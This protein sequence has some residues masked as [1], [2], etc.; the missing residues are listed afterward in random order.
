MRLETADYALIVSICSGFVALASFAWNV[1]SKWVYPKAKLRMH[2]AVVA[3]FREGDDAENRPRFLN[4]GMTNFGPTDITIQRVDVIFKPRRFWQPKPNA[5]VNPIHDLRM[6]DLAMG[7]FA[8]GLPKK[9]AVGDGFD[10]YLPYQA[11]TIGRMPIHRLGV[12]DNFGRLHVIPR[13]YIDKV[14]KELN[15][16]FPDAPVPP[17]RYE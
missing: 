5:I 2:F 14:R 3:I 17:V 12:R 10:L 16:A 15:E 1:W 4:I 13:S 8:G 11:D 7:P 6:P 9:L